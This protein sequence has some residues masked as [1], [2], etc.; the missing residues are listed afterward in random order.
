M[1]IDPLQGNYNN[2]ND[3]DNDNNNNNNNDN[4]YLSCENPELIFQLCRAV[5]AL[6]GLT[7]I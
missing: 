1:Y 5:K 6:Q 7:A 4:Q 3:N 2:D